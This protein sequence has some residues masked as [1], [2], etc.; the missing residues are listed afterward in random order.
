M[1]QFIEHQEIRQYPFIHCRCG[2]CRRPL[3][4]M[5]ACQTVAR[6]LPEMESLARTAAKTMLPSTAEETRPKLLAALNM[7]E[8]SVRQPNWT[9]ILCQQ[10]VAQSYSITGNYV[11]EDENGD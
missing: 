8:R 6:S 1:F 4:A 9:F 7:M 10:A 3:S 11:D 5:T 2:R